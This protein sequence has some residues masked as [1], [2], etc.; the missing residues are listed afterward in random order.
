MV[1]LLW[2][3]TDTG[4]SNVAWLYIGFARASGSAT[5]FIAKVI[6]RDDTVGLTDVDSSPAPGQNYTVAINVTS[7]DASTFDITFKAKSTVTTNFS[8]RGYVKA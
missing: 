3:N 6:S 1:E 4:G 5:A 7:A 2:R 8:L